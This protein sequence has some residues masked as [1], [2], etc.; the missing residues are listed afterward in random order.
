[1]RGGRGGDAQGGFRRPPEKKKNR[2]RDV[3]KREWGRLS[4]GVL[5]KKD[6]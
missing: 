6:Q 2:Y 4:S 3:K 1:V 5:R